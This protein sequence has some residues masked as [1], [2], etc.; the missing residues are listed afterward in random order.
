LSHA[1]GL[2]HE[3]FISSEN[4]EEKYLSESRNT[5]HNNSKALERYETYVQGHKVLHGTFGK[6][7]MK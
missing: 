1:N 6:K 5:L 2:R 3:H 4:K 7:K